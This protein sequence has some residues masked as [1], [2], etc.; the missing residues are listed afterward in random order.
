M[1]Q[2]RPPRGHSTEESIESHKKAK[3]PATQVPLH[4]FS[5]GILLMV[6]SIPLLPFSLFIRPMPCSLGE[7]VVPSVLEK[8]NAVVFFVLDLVDHLSDDKVEEVDV[9]VAKEWGLASKAVE[10]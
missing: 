3:K 6:S 2:H 10:G 8:V 1:T 7:L 9:E 4:C 5:G